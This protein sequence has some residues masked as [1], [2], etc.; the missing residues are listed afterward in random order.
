MGRPDYIPPPTHAKINQFAT[1]CFRDTGDADYIAARLAIR[2]GLAQPF[3]WSAEQAIEKYLK[4][5]LMLNRQ[6]TEGLCHKIGDALSRINDTLPFR[7]ALDEQESK[8]F[9]HLVDWDADRYLL[10]S[11]EMDSIELLRLDRLVWKLR[12]YCQPLDVIHYADSPSEAILLHNIQRIEA[13]IDG[14]RSGGHIPGAYLEQILQ[15]SNH[16]ARKALIWK[17]FHFTLAARKRAKFRAD[18]YAVNSPLFLNPELVDDVAK[19]MRVPKPIKEEARQ[20]ARLRE[21]ERKKAKPA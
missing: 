8:I 1:R 3:L 17:N 10:H 4:C 6:P 15:K 21:A 13:G 7:I 20:L 11:F 14:P 19:W 16:P 18:Y 2:S 12:Q 5:V 9:E